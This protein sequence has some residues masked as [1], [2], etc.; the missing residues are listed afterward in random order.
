MDQF[1]LGQWEPEL[2][3]ALHVLDRQLDEAMDTSNRAGRQGDDAGATAAQAALNPATTAET[4]RA[5]ASS[6]VVAAAQAAAASSQ[7]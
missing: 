4:T 5:S 2:L 1:E 7:A 6:A 3:A